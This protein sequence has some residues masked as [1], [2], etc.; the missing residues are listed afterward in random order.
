[1]AKQKF[2]IDLKLD[3]QR[4]QTRNDPMPFIKA[5]L[6][7][8][9]FAFSTI[10]QA[11]TQTLEAHYVHFSR[12]EVPEQLPLRI[13]LSGQIFHSALVVSGMQVERDGDSMTTLI[14]VALV[15]SLP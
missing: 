3:T 14:Q 6:L 5:L 13:H 11:D 10:A 2:Q 15:S 12:L 9:L 4:P 1:M 7:I 8:A